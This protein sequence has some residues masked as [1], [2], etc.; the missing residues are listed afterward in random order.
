MSYSQI[1][2]I[3]FEIPSDFTRWTATCHHNHR[4]LELGEEFAALYK[5]QY[6][7]LMYVWGHSYEFTDRNNWELPSSPANGAI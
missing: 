4:L 7:Y 1:R 6:L 5:R 3:K 2:V